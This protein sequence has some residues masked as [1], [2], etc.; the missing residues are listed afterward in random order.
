MTTKLSEI[1]PLKRLFA[2]S[3]LM[4]IAKTL[5]RASE[6]SENAGD[7]VLYRLPGVFSLS[8]VYRDE[9]VRLIKEANAFRIMKP[10]EKSEVSLSAIVTDEAALADL[11]FKRAT[12]QKLYAEGRVVFA[13]KIKY[14]ALFMRVMAE[15][16]KAS[17]PA[18]K[19]QELYG[20]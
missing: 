1:C 2:R 18:K 7:D 12:W 3:A 14:A 10:S 19:Y 20:E 11:K 4:K 15:G 13:G 17:L 9:V 16:D 5:A 6:N 8:L